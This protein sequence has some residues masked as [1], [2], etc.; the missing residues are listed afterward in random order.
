MN[1]VTNRTVQDVDRV[2]ELKSKGWS[3]LTT[4]EKTE[5]TAGMKGAYNSTDLNRVQEATAYIN[6]RLSE[7]GY[8]AEFTPLKTWSINDAPTRAELEAYLRNVRAI[9]DAFVVLETTPAAPTSM[10]RFNYIKAN[11]VEQILFDVDDLVTKMIASYSY[12]GECFGGEI[13]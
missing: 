1:L 2:L 9:R 6:E 11:D 12:S 8:E 5:W 4:E 13:T 7:C 10:T 3:N